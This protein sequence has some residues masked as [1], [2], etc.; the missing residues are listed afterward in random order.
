MKFTGH[1]YYKGKM[2]R[3]TIKI[4]NET[5]FKEGISNEG[6]YGTLIPMPVNGHT[7]IGDS[8]ITEEPSGTLPEIVGPGGFKHRHLA[9]ASKNLITAGIKA[10]NRFMERSGTL[11]YFDF[12]ENGIEGIKL[13]NGIKTRYIKPVV[14]GRPFK[15]DSMETILDNSKGCA[16]SSISDLEYEEAIRASAATKKSNKIFALHFS[17]NIREDIDKVLQLK[18]DFLVHGIEASENDLNKISSEGIPLVITPRSNIFYGKRPDYGKLLRA[19]VTIMLGTDNAF[20]TEPDMFAE[21]DFLYRYQKFST[22]ISPEEILR[23]SIENPRK[24]MKKMKLDIDEKY[25][26]F[27]NELLNEY[28][29]VTKKH[30]FRSRNITKH[31]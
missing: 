17:E 20:I 22:Y 19:G 1:I 2:R 11:A 27:R 24:F 8:F 6:E 30:Y 5:E 3:G 26:L 16:L 28:Q 7:H 12:R 13:I 31:E 23:F 15:N 10:S 18:P 4:G 9:N 29:I 21:M 14:L 25:I